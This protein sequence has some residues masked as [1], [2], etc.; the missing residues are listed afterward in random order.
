MLK[1]IKEEIPSLLIYCGVDEYL[2]EFNALDTDG[3]ISVIAHFMMKEIYEYYEKENNNTILWLKDICKLLFVESNP[4]GVKYVLS[5]I[6][7]IQNI[8]QA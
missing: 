7:P 3:V 2:Q 4:I 6:Y 5:K 1:Q 8:Y